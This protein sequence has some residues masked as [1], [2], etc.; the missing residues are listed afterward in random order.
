[1]KKLQFEDLLVVGGCAAI[2]AG[3]VQWSVI[4]ALVLGGAMMI[5]FGLMIGKVKGKK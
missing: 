2:L 3:V 4:A 1:M 5:G